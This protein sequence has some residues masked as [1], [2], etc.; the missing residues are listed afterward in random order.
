MK[1]DFTQSRKGYAKTLSNN[2]FLCG[3]F[4]TFAAL[5]EMIL[6]NHEH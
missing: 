1:E 3:L 6:S 2:A 5:R 4:V